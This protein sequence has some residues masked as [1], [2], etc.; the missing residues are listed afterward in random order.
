MKGRFLK[1]RL[2]EATP[3]IN[4]KVMMASMKNKYTVQVAN[5]MNRIGCGFEV[6][7]RQMC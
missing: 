5:E 2:R 6:Q 1:R 3:I 4:L 7:I